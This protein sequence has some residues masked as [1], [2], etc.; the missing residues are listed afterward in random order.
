MNTKALKLAL[1]LTSM[2]FVL[3]GNESSMCDTLFWKNNQIKQIECRGSKI[4]S[5]KDYKIVYDSSGQKT[6]EWEYK[7]Y[8]YHIVSFWKN[9]TQ[10][11]KYGNGY[12]EFYYDYGN[13]QSK[14]KV[15]KGEIIDTWEYYYPNGNISH[16]IRYESCSK[17]NFCNDLNLNNG[18]LIISKDSNGL[19]LGSN[20]NGIFYMTNSNGKVDKKFFVSNN[21]A[22]SMFVFKNDLLFQVEKMNSEKNILELSREYFDNTK[23]KVEYKRINDTFFQYSYF[24]TG[25]IELV[26]KQYDSLTHTLSYYPNGKLRINLLRM[27]GSTY[28]D[29]G[30]T[31]LWVRDKYYKE[32]DENGVEIK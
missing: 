24:N 27:N 15:D 9:N 1:F 18:S 13:L 16:I 29:N 11:V 10:F 6:E 21:K 30:M 23:L 28:N 32:W 5:L 8:R 19:V 17:S 7:S 25:Q 12:M 3:Y 22:D 26:S 2:S 31:E 14:G 4:Y 20:G